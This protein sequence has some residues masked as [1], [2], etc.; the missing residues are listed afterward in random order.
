MC[1]NGVRRISWEEASYVNLLPLFVKDPD[2]DNA[3]VG[4][5]IDV[6]ITSI[7]TAAEYEIFSSL[8]Q[9]NTTHVLDLVD[10][11][12]GVNAVDEWGQTPLMIAV[13]MNRIDIVAALLNTRKPKVDVNAAK[14]VSPIFFILKF[15][16]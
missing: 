9:G 7:T 14:P 12:V 6:T 3:D 8:R 13:Q 10:Q 5:S 2:V 4:V 16:D 15:I 1:K 11:H